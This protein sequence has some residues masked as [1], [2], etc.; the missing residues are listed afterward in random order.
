MAAMAA[1]AATVASIASLTDLAHTL[2]LLAFGAGIIA[3]EQGVDVR[4]EGLDRTELEDIM[5]LDHLL[6][7]DGGLALDHLVAIMTNPVVVRWQASEELDTFAVHFVQDLVVLLGLSLFKEVVESVCEKLEEFVGIQLEI[8]L[9][10]KLQRAI[11]FWS[12]LK[13]V[14]KRSRVGPAGMRV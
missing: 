9:T 14:V 1:I 10:E 6:Y 4:N 11:R 3:N 13:R 7:A 2:V 5:S 12:L 8:A